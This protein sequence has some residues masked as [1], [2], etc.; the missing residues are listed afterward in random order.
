M[1]D[2]GFVNSEGEFCF[3]TRNSASVT[4]SFMWKKS[5]C[6]E[7]GTEKSS[8]TDIRRGQSAPLASLIKPY[9][10]FQLLTNNRKVLTDPLPQHTS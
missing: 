7:K 2:V 3:E 5:H 1:N 9:I 10:L 4:Q 8:D 6:S